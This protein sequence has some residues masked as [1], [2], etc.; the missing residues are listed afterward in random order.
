MPPLS[1]IRTTLVIIIY[2]S[3]GHVKSFLKF[4]LSIWTDNDI[5]A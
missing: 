3:F 1:F 4:L 2:R 5:L